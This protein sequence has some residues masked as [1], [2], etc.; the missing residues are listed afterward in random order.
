MGTQ[1]SVFARVPA[2]VGG[3]GGAAGVAA[4]AL[5]A[6]LNIKLTSRAD[7][8]IGIRYFGE[9]GER[10]P[11][12]RTNLVARAVEMALHFREREF[13]GADF[14]IYSSVPVGVGLGSSTAAVLA[15]LVAA[16]RQYGL[17][18][19]EAAFLELAQVIENR[20]DNVRAAWRGGFVVLSQP[21]E[22]E[23]YQWT[24]VSE[25]LTLYVVVPE[26]APRTPVAP[27]SPAS[28]DFARAQA[29]LKFLAQPWN[30]PIPEPSAGILERVI[31]GGE[32]IFKPHSPGV[33]S[34]FVCGAGPAVGILVRGDGAEPAIKAVQD[35]FARSGVRCRT[36]VFRPSNVG[37][38]E[39]NSSPPVDEAFSTQ[40]L[41]EP[42]Y[43]TARLSV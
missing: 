27:D 34:A 5:N 43:K 9:N 18:L 17:G 35:S 15:G 8:Q 11:R 2:T 25:E 32:Q 10:V 29:W 13:T 37:A 4:L 30:S 12:D 42:L 23:D 28:G 22:P 6:T 14:E 1:R 31:A 7:G 26:G 33:L 19:D 20:R 41:T 16:D 38:K 40:G 3:F 39:F 21:G 24:V 36:A